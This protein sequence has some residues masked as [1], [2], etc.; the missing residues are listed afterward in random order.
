MVSR[1]TALRT[2]LAVIVATVS[3][4]G[5]TMLPAWTQQPRF[6]WRTPDEVATTQL[7]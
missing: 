1:R 5:V 6:W 3:W 2:V 4:R 7:D